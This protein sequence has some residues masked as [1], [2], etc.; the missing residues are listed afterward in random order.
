MFLN[1]IFCHFNVSGNHIFTMSLLIFDKNLNVLD[2][3]FEHPDRK[4]NTIREN[5]CIIF[6]KNAET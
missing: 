1:S 4:N 3:L 2:I 6:V 5:N